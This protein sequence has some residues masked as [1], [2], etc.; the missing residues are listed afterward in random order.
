MEN[1][2]IKNEEVFAE[3]T[4]AEDVNTIDENVNAIDEAKEEKDAKKVKEALNALMA[5]MSAKKEAIKKERAR[6]AA[7][8]PEE[9]KNE[10]EERKN[11]RKAKFALV[12]ANIV[13]KAKNFKK[14][15]VKG[16]A[17]QFVVYVK[18]HKKGAIYF[19]AGAALVATS[20][21]GGCTAVKHF[22][23]KNNAN[24][25]PV[26]NEDV[27]PTLAPTATPVPTAIPTVAPTATP[28]PT[29]TPV[30]TAVPTQAPVAEMNE[31]QKMV[32]A[33]ADELMKEFTEKGLT[34][35]GV[36]DE[37]LKSMIE[38]TYAL[39]NIET[40]GE[41]INEIA[42]TPAERK[43]LYALAKFFMHKLALHNSS[44]SKSA[45]YI[46]VTSL[47]DIKSDKDIIAALEYIPT[48]K[49]A[50]YA[51]E[52]HDT[53]VDAYAEVYLRFFKEQSNDNEVKFEDLTIGG[54]MLSELSLAEA[55]SFV[56]GSS[57]YLSDELARELDTL[58]KK[59]FTGSDFAT[60]NSIYASKENTLTK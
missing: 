4:I 34:V 57:D 43:A 27:T 20:V 9:R 17:K 60:I 36:T 32:S 7:L 46:S 15:G 6:K 24:E 35:K 11:E 25:N 49:K 37:E 23:K 55:T 56:L 19:A 26:T 18:D 21:I 51:G 59:V 8:T 38:A 40:L 41:D 16:N 44:L 45:Q 42:G 2:E 30:P 12:K 29:A 10:R 47:S 14:N 22:S 28:I 5:R 54:K 48:Y 58:S 52:L 53:C 31:V 13:G 1:N 33:R 50:L 3:N 39:V